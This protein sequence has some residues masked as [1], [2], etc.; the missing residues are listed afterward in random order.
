MNGG[1]GAFRCPTALALKK[2]VE[3]SSREG[4]FALQTGKTFG[5]NSPPHPRRLP[6]L[7]QAYVDAC[8][9]CTNAV[10]G[11]MRAGISKLYPS[12]TQ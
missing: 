4:T 1:R 7:D 12:R 10:I 9:A 3:A 2:N 11:A 5:L 6:M 8:I